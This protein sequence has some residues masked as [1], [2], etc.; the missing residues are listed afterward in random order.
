MNPS[1]SHPGCTLIRVTMLDVAREVQMSVSTVCRALRDDPQIAA[2]TRARIRTKAESLGYKP[3]PLLSAFASRRRGRMMGIDASTIA[4]ITKF[5]SA[6][7]WKTHPYYGKLFEGAH[8]RAGSLGYQLEHFWLGEPGMTARRLSDILY[9]RGIS[10]LF[11]APIPAVRGH[12]SMNWSRF[13][14]I[15]VGYSLLRP[16]LH[17]ASAHHFHGILTS[18]RALRRRG[19]RRIGF[20]ICKNTSKRVDG[21]WL[22]GFLLCQHVLAD[23]KLSFFVFDD[24]SAPQIS[25]WCR[26]EKLEV[27][28]G[29]EP[30]VLDHLRKANLVPETVDYASGSWDES[31]PEIAGLDQRPQEI[32]GTAIDLLVAQLQRGEKGIPKVP[33][34]TLVEGRWRD[35]A[36]L[37]RHP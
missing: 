33:L 8:A 3:D 27:V 2:S 10:A 22:A 4:F 25:T 14:A 17:R 37:R 15:T 24:A 7:Y 20:G 9:S 6:S 13:A 36:S 18:V 11:L 32:G 26:K 12:L 16:N 1:E 29:A 23:V 30:V 31:Q 21:Q 28:I 34:A 5:P 35:G 19:Y